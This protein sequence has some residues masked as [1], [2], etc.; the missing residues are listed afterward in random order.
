MFPSVSGDGSTIAFSSTATTLVPNDTNG[1]TDVFLWHRP[2]PPSVGPAVTT[3][4]LR[5]GAVGA[6]YSMELAATGGAGAYTWAAAGLPAGLTV[7]GGRLSGTP[8]VAGAT[9]VSVTVTDGAGRR[10]TRTIMLTIGARG[11]S[12]AFD[13]LT[14]G[15]GNSGLAEVSSDGRYLVFGSIAS[16]LAPGDDNMAVDVFTFDQATGVLI[17]LTSGNPTMPIGESEDPWSISA[18]GRYVAFDSS[19]PTIVAGDGNGVSDVFLWDRT[20]GTTTRITNGNR[21]SFGPEISADGGTIAFTSDAGNLV[22]GDTDTLPD[23]YLWTRA[24]GTFRRL[25]ANGGT[26]VALSGDGST[27]TFDSGSDLISLRVATGVRTVVAT[28]S[29]GSVPA[30]L[31]ADGRF[32]AYATVTEVILWDRTTGLARTLGP[33]GTRS[34][35]AISADGATV[36]YGWQHTVDGANRTDVQLW[37]A[38]PGTVTTIA[39]G[40]I[41]GV[42]PTISD[43]GTAVAFS[44]NA[45][46]LVPDDTNGKSDLFVWHRPPPVG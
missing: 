22:A 17:P 9:P 1:T 4:W 36:V 2:P 25:S 42:H 12:T 8:T 26:N 31:S 28:N 46:H 18:D 37:Q 19:S 43:D 5:L 27:A 40:A 34:P 23:A 41:S 15:N 3:G 14:H 21:R 39:T 33:S 35:P 11:S 7:S 13:R 38:G 16:D 6:P 20:T 44:T 45:T 29:S 32:I 10:A 30:D 24:G